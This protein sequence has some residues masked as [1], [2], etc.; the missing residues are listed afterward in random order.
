MSPNGSDFHLSKDAIERKLHEVIVSWGMSAFSSNIAYHWIRR[1]VN[2]GKG[3]SEWIHVRKWILLQLNGQRRSKHTSPWQL[4]CPEIIPLLQ[5]R[6]IWKTSNLPWVE[7]L[8]SSFAVIKEE[9]LGL[10]SKQGFQP[11]RAP[12]LDNDNQVSDKLGTAAHDRGEWNVFYLFLHNVDFSMN[13]SLCPQ[14]VAIIESIESQYDHAFFSALAPHTHVK[15]HNGPTNKKLRCHLPLVVQKDQCRIRVGDELI[16]VEEGKCLVFD[17]SFEHEAWN[18][19]PDH[20]RI[21]LIVDV[22]HP[23]LTR[24][25]RRFFNFVRNAELRACKKYCKKDSSNFYSI[26]QAGKQSKKSSHDAIWK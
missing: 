22:W 24:E 19:D 15:K 14:T 18:D 25:E 21:V 11:Y 17:D 12:S 16:K 1:A 2:D 26:I 6:P 23:D 20:S 8:E 3:D 13:R 9:L 7:S 10:Q 4:G 5:S